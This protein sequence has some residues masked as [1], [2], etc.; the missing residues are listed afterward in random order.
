[1]T[2]SRLYRTLDRVLPLKAKIEAHL[3]ERIGE[4]FSPDFDILLYDVTST[5]FEGE[6]KRNPQAKRGHSR[7]HRADCL[8]VDRQASRCASGLSS[9]P[10][11][12]LWGTR[13][14][15]ATGTT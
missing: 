13:S 10:T 14:S 5:Y 12:S 2:D 6:A 7:D 1:M 3:K 11:V 8:S 4:L 9:R 15:R